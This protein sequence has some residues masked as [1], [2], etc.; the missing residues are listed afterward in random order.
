M[1]LY[2]LATNITYE[3]LAEVNKNLMEA[4][5]GGKFEIEMQDEE[6]LLHEQQFDIMK[7]GLRTIKF[8]RVLLRS[9]APYFSGKN[10]SKKKRAQDTCRKKFLQK[11][12]NIK[13]L[14]ELQKFIRWYRSK[15]YTLIDFSVLLDYSYSKM[16][17]DLPFI[18]PLLLSS[19]L[20]S[21]LN[22]LKNEHEAKHNF[23]VE[24]NAE[25]L[26]TEKLWILP[27]DSDYKY[28]KDCDSTRI[29]SVFLSGYYPETPTVE[30]V[31]EEKN[32]EKAEVIPYLIK[33]AEGFWKKKISLDEFK[34]R[35]A[36]YV[37]K[38]L[39]IKFF[40]FDD[41]PASKL[42]RVE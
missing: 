6:S 25:D 28:I 30:E 12:D 17:P 2:E 32:L 39:D 13:E 1:K 10:A 24:I 16:F 8:H 3:S 22:E 19:D 7:H 34:R 37:K 36:E 23:I 29:P 15:Y 20:D 4:F 35:E 14:E 42:R 41:I 40:Y 5:L 21:L 26:C 9:T 27:L 31:I 11:I 33:E 18:K 38:G